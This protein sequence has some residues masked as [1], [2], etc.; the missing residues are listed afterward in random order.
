MRVRALTLWWLCSTVVVLPLGSLAQTP[1]RTLPGMAKIP[2]IQ[3]WNAVLRDK[4]YTQAV[5]AEGVAWRCS[6]GHCQ[7]NAPMREDPLPACAALVAQAGLV[8]EFG[9]GKQHLDA[10]ALARCN[11]AR[12]V[13]SGE[14]RQPPRTLAKP[15]AAPSQPQLARPLA[16][17]VSPQ[18][19]QALRG[20][21]RLYDDLREKLRKAEEQRDT[22]AARDRRA[23]EAR[24]ARGY[25][26][27]YGQ[28]EDCDDNERGSHPSANETCDYKDNNC[29]GFVDEG[30]RMTLFLDAD[31]DTHGDPAQAVA[32][33]PA[34]QARAA[35]EGRWLVPNGNDCDDTDS[36]A[37]EGC[38]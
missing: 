36:S 4:T 26:V 35:A 16:V 11:E 19:Q 8:L 32:V 24:V 25:T 28:G 2:L 34:D 6:K 33:C 38:E 14:L 13:S 17:P 18:L 30:Q 12:T 1:V 10:A 3:P 7:A 31:G 5:S 37:W 23:E 22:P 29:N 15:Q 20:K 21:A 9:L 27:K